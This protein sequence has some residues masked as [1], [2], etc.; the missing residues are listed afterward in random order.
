[1]DISA[2]EGHD[3]LLWGALKISTVIGTTNGSCFQNSIIISCLSNDPKKP[4]AN[5]INE[6][7][8]IPE[9]GMMVFSSKKTYPLK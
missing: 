5:Y 1:M 2:N 4:E 3:L 9:F 8:R 6:N 7:Q